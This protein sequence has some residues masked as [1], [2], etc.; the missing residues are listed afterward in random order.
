MVDTERTKFHT[1]ACCK[2]CQILIE[3]E[4]SE[5]WCRLASMDGFRPHSLE[6]LKLLLV[7]KRT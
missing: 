5:I 2:Q 4:F 6:C 7:T 3:K 1:C